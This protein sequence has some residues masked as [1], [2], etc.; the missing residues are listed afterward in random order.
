MFCRALSYRQRPAFFVYLNDNIP[1]NEI[2]F[3]DAPRFFFR[4]PLGNG[5]ET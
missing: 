5:E 1:D 3:Q 4:V 2:S